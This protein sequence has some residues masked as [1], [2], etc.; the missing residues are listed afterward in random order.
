MSKVLFAAIFL[1]DT[2]FRSQG[3]KILSLL[4]SRRHGNTLSLEHFWM[5]GGAPRKYPTPNG[6]AVSLRFEKDQ[7]AYRIVE[8]RRASTPHVSQAHEASNQVTIVAEDRTP[9]VGCC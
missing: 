7:E 4:L 6:K 1:L 3:R 8:T 9:L 2:Q 5:T